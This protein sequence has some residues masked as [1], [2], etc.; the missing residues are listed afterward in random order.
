MGTMVNRKVI[1]SDKYMSQADK[2][3][4]QLKQRNA[5]AAAAYQQAKA[6]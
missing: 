3:T 4:G 1:I 6:W 5:T 2:L